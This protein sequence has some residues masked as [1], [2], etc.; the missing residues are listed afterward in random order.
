MKLII[1]WIFKVLRAQMKRHGKQSSEKYFL[2]TTIFITKL[3]T[4]HP[5]LFTENVTPTTELYKA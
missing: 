1:Q 4:Y 2:N 5:N 3:N